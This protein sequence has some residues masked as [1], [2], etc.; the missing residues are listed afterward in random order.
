MT[1]YVVDPSLYPFSW[2][3]TKYIT[4]G[5]PLTLSNCLLSYGEGDYLRP[6]KQ[7]QCAEDRH[8]RYPN[9]QAWSRRYQ[10]LP[11]EVEFPN[12][13]EGGSRYNERS[14][15]EASAGW[16]DLFTTRITSYINNVHPNR[17]QAFYKTLE[18]LID[19][20]I[21]MLNRSLMELR[22][23]NYQNVRLHVAILESG[24]APKV[25]KDVGSF[26][27]A[28]QRT[29]KQY[30]NRQ[31]R[32]H[33]WLYVDLKRE[34][35]GR[36]L[37]LVCEVQHFHLLDQPSCKGEDWHVQG[38]RNEYIC[39]TAILAFSIHNVTQPRLSFRRRVW[40]E[41]ADLAWG[42][43][44]EPPFAPEIYGAKTGDPAVQHIGDVDLRE[45]RLI[46]FPNIWQTRLLPFELVDKKRPG[47]VKILTLHL[48]D[49]SRRIISTSRV[50]PQRRDWWADEVRLR[51]A[52]LWRLPNEIWMKIVNE[53]GG[54]PLSPDQAEQM[55]NEFLEERAEFH[56]KQTKAMMDYSEW[57]LDSD[58]E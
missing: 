7:E 2:E 45:G 18:S 41:E 44:T 12:R 58:A 43:I 36:G 52:V 13:G 22:A 6:P 49:P 37:Q 21:P 56:I 11:F 54:L 15:N 39:A 31:Y 29:T 10:W 46:T 17:H 40:T 9:D 57:D 4:F 50:P 32:W 28:Q 23:P 14:T 55:R 30:I 25:T 3:A 20:A 53:V 27:P 8:Y 47:R 5:F 1:S 38:Q 33:D 16:S 48:I 34:F 19:T 26:T 42:Y 24:T 35:C 51:N